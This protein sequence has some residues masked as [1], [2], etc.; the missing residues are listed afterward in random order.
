MK[1]TFGFEPAH[2]LAFASM[3]NVE[4]QPEMTSFGN[5]TA[6]FASFGSIFHPLIPE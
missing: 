3:P 6:R 1:E 5:V 2:C 4:K